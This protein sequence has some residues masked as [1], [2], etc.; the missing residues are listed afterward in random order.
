M[1]PMLISTTCNRY[2]SRDVADSEALVIRGAM[3][4]HYVAARQGFAV[5]VA[6][7]GGEFEVFVQAEVE[8]DEEL[9]EIVLSQVLRR[10]RGCIVPGC[11]GR[12]VVD[13]AYCAE[14]ATLLTPAERLAILAGT[15]HFA[16]GK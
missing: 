5:G 9:A 1:R 7:A 2:C 16:E 4:G 11:A 3:E 15:V 8:A 10:V 13:G 12:A 6:P 14:D